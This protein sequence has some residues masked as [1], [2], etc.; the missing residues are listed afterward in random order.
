MFYS[1]IRLIVFIF[2]LLGVKT[3]LFTQKNFSKV[4]IGIE[5]HSS[6]G[7][8][9]RE[10]NGEFMFASHLVEHGRLGSVSPAFTT[11]DGAGRE[12][13]QKLISY[14]DTS[15][16]IS[17]PN[18]LNILDDSFYSYVI[19]NTPDIDSLTHQS[20]GVLEVDPEGE[21]ELL[22]HFQDSDHLYGN[23]MV[24]TSDSTLAL[25]T[26]GADTQ[27]M[28]YNSVS[29]LNIRTGES[30]TR[31]Y[32]GGYRSIGMGDIRALPDGELLLTFKTC[33]KE[34]LEFCRDIAVL[35]KIGA[36]GEI[37]W[38]YES[39]ESVKWSNN[40]QYPLALP[41]RNG[42]IAL[43][44]TLDTTVYNVGQEEWYD[45]GTATIFII[46]ENGNFKRE[47]RITGRP[48]LMTNLELLTNGDILGMGMGALFTQTDGVRDNG[49]FAFRTTSDGDVIWERAFVDLQATDL[50]NQIFEDGL[51]TPSGDL[52]FVGS[53][54]L[55]D[56][57]ESI[58]YRAWVVKLGADGCFN[59]KNCGENLELITETVVATTSAS[60]DPSRLEVAPNPASK[61]FS[62][63]LPVSSTN[64]Q[65]HFE[66]LDVNGR[67][68]RSEKI[69]GNTHTVAANN[70]SEGA[71][72]VR[73]RSDTELFTAK[74]IVQKN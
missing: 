36:D 44:W 63:S 45:E 47:T 65:R 26:S 66:L 61:Q 62:F 29:I 35:Q 68:V 74:V 14:Q 2:C 38:T 73:V 4:Y 25:Y 60:R 49:A 52:L 40:D 71:Y 28:Y 56:L 24:C 54:L 21:V 33:Q 50:N 18:S 15:V 48:L 31:S 64:S 39:E 22:F 57:G 8:T 37:V 43:A 30:T 34:D 53:R 72:I 1:L 46:D 3:S 23:S 13:Y 42:D 67:M 17:K 20:I 6:F 69:A 70:L 16:F 27:S 41:L 59:P 12:I 10:V 11:I 9:V 19:M 58:A 7:Q 32:Q 5:E 55:R 51:E